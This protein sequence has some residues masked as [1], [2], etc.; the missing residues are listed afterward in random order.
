MIIKGHKNGTEI[1]ADRAEVRDFLHSNITHVHVLACG[2]NVSQKL[3]LV[4]D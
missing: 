4:F 2:F 3:A 1:M